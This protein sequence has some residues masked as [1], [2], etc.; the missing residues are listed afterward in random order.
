MSFNAN[1]GEELMKKDRKI[2]E[3]TATGRKARGL[4]KPEVLMPLPANL[5][6]MPDGYTAFFSKLKERI[7]RE[8]IKAVLSANS[9]MVLMYWDIGQAILERQ[10]KEGWGAKVIDRLSHDL[11][12]VFPE[13]TGFSPRNLKYMRKFAESWPER[14]LVQRTVALIPWRSNLPCWIN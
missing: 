13:M 11:K 2:T 7:T 14:E 5:L 4:S 12:A 3:T 6:E 8:R 1:G 10:R 9:A